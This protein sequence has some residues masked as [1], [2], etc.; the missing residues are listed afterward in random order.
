MQYEWAYGS[1]IDGNCSGIGSSVRRMAMKLVSGR[2]IPIGEQWRGLPGVKLKRF[3]VL[4]LGLFSH[5]EV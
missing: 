3:K 5:G 2:R 4:P 1:G